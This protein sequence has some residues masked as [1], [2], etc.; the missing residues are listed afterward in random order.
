MARRFR[1]YEITNEM[2][3]QGGMAFIYKG[4]QTALNRPVAVKMLNPA[5]GLNERFIVRFE[6]EAR[7]QAQLHH[8]NVVA[9]FDYGRE[10]D[11]Y[12]IVME[13]VE[14]SD[15]KSLFST[16]KK[17]PLEI[18]LII[19]EQIAIGL[20]AA[21]ALNIVHRD[22]KPSNILLSKVGDVK[23]ADFGLAM[24]SRD[25]EEMSAEAITMPGTVI[26]TLAY[27]SPEQHEGKRVD[28]RADQFALGIMAY[29]LLTGERPFMGTESEVR[30]RTLRAQPAPI[31]DRCPLA[32]PEIEE[33]VYRLLAKH[34]EERY[35]SM[36][37]VVMAIR[38]SLE[39]I[40]PTGTLMKYRQE[41]LR[42][43]MLDAKAVTK[44]LKE[45][46]I[47]GHFEKG[48]S[49][50]REPG[51]TAEAIRELRYVLILDPGNKEA[52]A[53]LS[54]LEKQDHTQVVEPKAADAPRLDYSSRRE[55]YTPRPGSGVRPPSRPVASSKSGPNWK[56]FAM[57][58]IPVVVL[59]VLAAVI[60]PRL[61]GSSQAE[62]FVSTPQ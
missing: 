46:S 53:K 6:R 18:S 10:D 27:M 39:S 21:H 11:T 59:A 28:A 55:S 36:R 26:G 44:N 41:H 20:E 57:I 31:P 38:D 42:E 34:P 61:G 16:H 7:S 8:P 5:L 62:V 25:R 3:G 49:L 12:Y 19:L 60:L 48:M 58:G 15:L 37:D 9:V 33:F 51:R 17:L 13:L 14:G 1:G 30:E 4:V 35:A 24:D 22:L 52:K 43:F 54:E 50:V 40:D 2:L 23:I 47:E 45:R 29:E 56:L 32:T